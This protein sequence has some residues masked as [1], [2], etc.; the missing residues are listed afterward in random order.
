MCR[1][2]LRG[3]LRIRG[4]HPLKEQSI[5]DVRVTFPDG[6]ENRGKET[7]KILERH[8]AD[9][10]RMYKP[11]CD[12]QGLDFVPF[13][14]TTDGVMG[15][16]ANELISTLGHKLGKKWGKRKG[17][18]L[19]WIRARLSIAIVRASS[20]CIRGSRTDPHPRELEAGFVDGAALTS[21]L[22]N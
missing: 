8:E 21:L 18:V 13:V 7:P 19:S 5:I 2:G 3:D 17:V 15:G 9:K 4:V 6:G 1:D 10:R 14:V 16:L 20:A 22:G 11:E 12:R